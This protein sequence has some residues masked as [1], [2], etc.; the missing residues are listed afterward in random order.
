[1]TSIP[2][3]AP[4]N[5]GNGTGTG[6]AF[7]KIILTGEHAVVYGVP[8]LAAGIDR[9]ASAVATR[10]V[11]DQVVFAT[12]GAAAP[13]EPSPQLAEALAR[14][15]AALAVESP[16]DV[17]LTTDLP[18]AAGLGCS[19]ALGVAAARAVLAAE[20]R[21]ALP[22]EVL[23]AAHAWE[24]VFHGNPSGV[25]ATVAA[26]GGVVSFVRGEAPVAVTLPTTLHVAIGHTGHGSSTKTMVDGVARLRD[27]STASVDQTFE[28]I[29]SVTR[30]AR[31]AL[32]AGDL[33][34]VGQLLDMNQML[35]AG[36]FVSTSE[37]ENLCRIAREAGAL[38]AKLTGAGG[39][40][41]V[42]ALCDGP[43]SQ[44]LAAW[45]A[46]GFACFATTIDTGAPAAS[47]TVSPSPL[48]PAGPKPQP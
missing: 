11:A 27:R 36:L 42:I 45:S 25:D 41:C 34:A 47:P 14:A 10:S 31:L 2:P 48:A 18:A 3:R 23:A 22:E 33:K 43:P 13:T 7:G 32:E 44:V 15:R 20:G 40:G 8:A 24:T 4:S 29:K 28:A 35:L 46:A 38:G 5:S 16:Y 12:A 26:L 37:I 19:A 1:V 6:R 9:G 30:N 17:S 39:G 21:P